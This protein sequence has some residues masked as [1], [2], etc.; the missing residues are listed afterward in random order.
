MNLNIIY[1]RLRLFIFIKTGTLPVL[2]M[3]IF[4]ALGSMT[5]H[6]SRHFC[7]F[8]GINKAMNGY[9]EKQK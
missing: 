4:L 1:T 6:S 2:L 5:A 7:K 9:H 8:C 3:S